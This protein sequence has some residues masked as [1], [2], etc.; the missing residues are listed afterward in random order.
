MRT[1]G[2]LLFPRF[3]LLAY[4]L[5]TECLRL[6]NKAAGRPLFRAA[7]LTPD[8]RPVAAS[9][10][11][12]VTP[13][14]SLDA[15]EPARPAFPLLVLC[16]GY[17]P[18]A[19]LDRPTAARLRRLGRAGQ[20]FAGFDTGAIVLA[21]L[22]LLT[23]YRAVAHW[24]AAAA[25][26]ER[27]PGAEVSDALYIL[28]RDRLTAAGG[29]ATADAMLSWI[30]REDGADLAAAVARDLVHGRIRP[31]EERQ[32]PAPAAPGDGALAPALALMADHL[33]EPLPTAHLARRLKVSP[34]TLARRFQARF[35]Q[36]PQAYYL[37]LRLD[38]ARALLAQ[39]AP[40]ARASG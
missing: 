34:R 9:N 22:G 18:L 15:L 29:M 17:E 24:E 37:G 1:V 5:A 23:G 14:G 21:E 16:A 31:A 19:A 8:G 30:A 28:D 11:V 13:E 25:F 36:S 39:E 32:T 6:A 33:A 4:V 20:A 7:A 3:Q 40:I 27:Y 10:G 2:F 35:G 38:R 26:R 12:A